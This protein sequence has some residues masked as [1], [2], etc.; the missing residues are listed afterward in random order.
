MDKQ[1]LNQWLILIKKGQSL[2]VE[3]QIASELAKPCSPMT[4]EHLPRYITVGCCKPCEGGGGGGNDGSQ[5]NYMVGTGGG[6]NG[7]KLGQ[8]P[9][10]KVLEGAVSVGFGRYE[11]RK[12][13]QFD[14]SLSVGT[15]LYAASLDSVSLIK[16]RKKWRG[17][18]DAE[19]FD[20]LKKADASADR[21]PLGF[22]SFAMYLE[23]KLREKNT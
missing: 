3:S 21:V 20:A 19:V 22:R 4:P 11:Q 8:E 18:T 16:E 5:A 2:V 15:D 10:G 12:F 17:L 23:D 14:Q 13:V 6:G 7:A 9:V 1:L